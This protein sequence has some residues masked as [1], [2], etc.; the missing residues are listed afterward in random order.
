MVYGKNI[1]EIFIRLFVKGHC[2]SHQ[3]QCGNGRCIPVTWQC[4]DDDDCGD[5]TDEVNCEVRTCSETEF[6]CRNAKCVPVRW[7]CDSEDDCGDRSD[8]DSKHCSNK[9]CTLDQ[10]TCGSPT[11]LCIPI[12]WKC[13]NQNDC[14]DGSDEKDCR[15]VT[16]TEEEFTCENNK[17]ITQRW[18]CDLDNDCGDMSDE[19]DCPNVTCSA[20]EFMC[21]NGRCIPDRWRCDGDV[22]CT[23]NSDELLCPKQT[24]KTCSPAEFKCGSEFKCIQKTWLCDGHFDCSDRSDEQNCTV[25]CSDTE[26]TCKNKRQCIQKPLLCDGAKDCFD[27]SDEEDC[28]ILAPNSCN[29]TTHFDC[30]GISCITKNLVCNGK[31]DCGN[32]EDEPQS[33]YINECLRNNGGCSQQCVDDIIGFHCQ[34]LPGYKLSDNQTCDDIDEC[35]IPGS[36][37]QLC[38]N[39]KGSYKCSCV[40][41]YSIEPSNHRL[42]KAKEGHGELLF[43][44]RRDIRKISLEDS[45]YTLAVSGLRSAVAVDF[46]YYKNLLVWTDVLEEKIYSAPLDTG[47]PLTEVVHDQIQTP[48]G[49]AVDWIYHNIYW[50]D[51]GRNTISVVRLDGSMRKTLIQRNLDEPRAIVVNPLEGWMFWADWGEPAKIERAGMDGTYRSEIVSKHLRWPNGLAID[52]VNRKLYYA[53]A[54]YHSLCSVN[55]DGSN[56]QVIVMSVNDI[57]HPFALDVFEDWVYWTDWKSESIL[58]TDKFSGKN[59]EVVASGVAS[60]MGVRVMHQNKQPQ[61]MNYCGARN[62]GCSHLCLPSPKIS[63]YSLKFSC[64]CPDESV[65]ASDLQHCIISFRSGVNKEYLPSPLTSAMLGSIF[66]PGASASRRPIPFR[67]CR[68]SAV[69]ISK[70]ALAKD[71]L[72]YFY[73]L[74][75]AC[76]RVVGADNYTDVTDSESVPLPTSSSAQTSSE[77]AHEP[78]LMNETLQAIKEEIDDS[79]KI[80]GI[81]IGALGIICFI[82]TVVGFF[83]YKQYL[84]RNI[85]SMNFD[86]PVYRKT[87][88]DQFSLEKNQYQPARSYPSVSIN[89]ASLEPLTSPGTNEFV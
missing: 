63:V 71:C 77:S 42:C 11:G 27:E 14:A 40:E 13:D 54:L 4:D 68:R 17:C 59:I 75:F 62:G 82:L 65:L 83:I 61:G 16:C 50:T 3:F 49:V 85:T 46:D 80:A 23:D 41:G 47:Y 24:L 32:W 12:S 29:S 60:P 34:C 67:T 10:F 86:N 31:N 58:K 44:N 78:N 66:A 6:K 19:K 89:S 2:N 15:K 53:D 45:E 38:N 51:T 70:M 56:H 43:A 87:T 74:V 20:S 39:T 25:T 21:A 52:L 1:T 79:G 69:R 36:C 84:R 57:K 28:P 5:Q 81:V 35:Q 88:E 37:S 9:T 30:G 73:V 55:F 72:L 64:A 8:E 76:S 22:D 7:L 33:C 18:R 48:D 26:F